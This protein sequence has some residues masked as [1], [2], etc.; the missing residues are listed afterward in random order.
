[1]RLLQ[2]VAEGERLPHW[3]S[4]VCWFDGARCTFLVAPIPFNVVLRWLRC[5][6]LWLRT[7][8]DKSVADD[9]YDAGFRHGFDTAKVLYRRAPTTTTEG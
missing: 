3:Y 2:Q 7:H 1:M 9:V 6:W 4:G 8:C 5:G